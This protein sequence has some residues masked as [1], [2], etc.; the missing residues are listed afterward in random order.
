MPTY[1]QG[2]HDSVLR[3]HRWRTAENSAGYLLPHL[4]HGMRVLD[5]GCGPGTITSAL[6]DLVG[7]DGDVLGI[8]SSEEIIAAVRETCTR[9]NVRFAV[10]DISRLDAHDDSFDISHAHQVLQHL[11]DPVAA[12]REM[13]R[14][15]RPGGLIAARD[16]D[17]A[18]MT[19]YPSIRGLD[20]WLD[21]YQSVARSHHAEPDA[22]RRLLSWAIQAGLPDTIPSA[23]VWC[24]ATPEDRRWWGGLQAE[25]IVDSRIAE[26]AVAL[27]IADKDDLRRIAAAWHIWSKAHDGWFTIV[28]GEILCRVSETMYSG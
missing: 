3:A 24:F 14:V 11:P 8:D 9:S 6:G 19:W 5:V 7:A 10:Q 26:Q 16:A 13:A 28:H 1:M 23:D 2:H 25:R 12:L 21:V 20:E 15:T 4:R 22:G 27:G 17:Y 18:A